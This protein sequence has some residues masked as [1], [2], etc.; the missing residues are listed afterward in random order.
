V[1]GRRGGEA[2]ALVKRI[3]RIYQERKKKRKRLRLEMA[4]W[5]WMIIK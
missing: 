2:V 1:K 3:Q 4:L 5:R